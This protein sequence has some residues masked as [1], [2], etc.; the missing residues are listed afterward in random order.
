VLKFTFTRL[1]QSKLEVS[2][3]TKV[4]YFSGTYTI[5]LNAPHF[6]ELLL[7]HSPPPISTTKI[8][9]ALVEMGFPQ[10]LTLESP[11]LCSW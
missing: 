7:L 1:Y 3:F 11:V 9:V 5:A 6:K 2:G 4:N 8:A 10:K